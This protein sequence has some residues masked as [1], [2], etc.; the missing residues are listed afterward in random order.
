MKHSF[1]APDGESVI[2]RAGAMRAIFG[3][4]HEMKLCSYEGEMK[5]VH[6]V[7]PVRRSSIARL[8]TVFVLLGAG[9]AS[10]QSS[11]MFIYPSKGQSQAQQDKD[12][13]EC[14]TWAVQQTGFDPSRPQTTSARPANTQPSQPH[15]LKGATRGAALGA[16][17]GAITGNAGKGA[18]AGAAMGGIVGGFRRR[19]ERLRQ[20]DIQADMAAAGNS[21][22]PA[23]MRA[24]AA[25]LQGRGYA[26]N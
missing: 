14:H 18:A 21:G 8:I 3:R 22:R 20:A 26:V 16:V 6:W 9:F 5:Y 12:R 11:D 15:V 17:G 1:V 2:D 23:Y 25:C 4:Q 7:G 10:A 24:M 19:D 13:Y